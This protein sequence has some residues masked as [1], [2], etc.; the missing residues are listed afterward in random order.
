M[1]YRLTRQVIQLKNIY[2]NLNLTQPNHNC[3]NNNIN[4]YDFI[5]SLEK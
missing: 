4:K 3:E 5:G 2:K 1:L